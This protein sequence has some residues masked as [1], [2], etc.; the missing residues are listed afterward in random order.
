MNLMIKLVLS[1]LIK[2]RVEVNMKT[3]DNI[4]EKKIT[5]IVESTCYLR[6]KKTARL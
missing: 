6:S 4:H 1:F 5:S 3:A 2:Y